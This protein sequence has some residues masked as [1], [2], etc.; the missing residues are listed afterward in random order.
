MKNL[1]LLMAIFALLGVVACS[2]QPTDEDEIRAIVRSEVMAVIAEVKQGPPGEQGPL[3]SNE[4]LAGLIQEAILN[5][6]K[7]LRG[8]QGLRGE[9]GPA[10]IRGPQ[11]IPGTAQLPQSDRA[12]LNRVNTIAS[13]LRNLRSEVEC[14]VR[15]SLLCSSSLHEIW[16]STLS[17]RISSLETDIANLKSIVRQLQ[18]NA[19]RHTT[20]LPTP[21]H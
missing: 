17:S 19:H 10:G 14:E 12:T 20:R 1:Q 2:Q 11:G 3:P 6:R 21:R 9:Q 13:D 16:G 15:G 5:M 4:L 18:D 7:E 8:P